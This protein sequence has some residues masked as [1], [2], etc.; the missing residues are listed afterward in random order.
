MKA[1][2]RVGLGP[3][4][5]QLDD[6]PEPSPGPGQVKIRVRA[7]G[8]C[9]TDLHG[10]PSLQPPVIIG[11]EIAGDIVELGEGVRQR[12]VGDRVTSETTASICGECMF[13]K[14]EDY[15]LCRERKGIATRAP[16]GFAEYLVVREPSTHVLPDHIDY[17][18]GALSEPVACAVHAILEQAKVH[19]GE[20]VAV[21]G[22]GPLGLLVAHV[23]AASQARVIVAGV[24][25]D[26]DRLE[27]SKQL[28]AERT[29]DVTAED[30]T[31]VAR[32]MT[33]GYGA[34][35]ALDCTGVQAG[36]HAALACLRTM[37]RYV[38]GG[39][40]HREVPLDLDDIFFGREITMFG[41]HTHKPSS[42][43]TTMQLL[44]EGKVDPSPLVAE[45]LPLTDWKRGFEMVRNKTAIKVI[46]EP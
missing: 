16:G 19:P 10:H 14:S 34:D 3:D 6:V 24:T 32:Q 37:G 17:G 13:C 2:L 46:L 25:Q 30:R 12:K 33:D 45:T 9:G 8:V 28:G 31:E 4:D 44:G 18:T 43:R 29:V 40:L 22:P 39:I 23:A 41:S 36:V 15:N 35:V 20:V 42:W 21:V 1:L 26:A 27:L 5:I 7:A 11:H 38:Q